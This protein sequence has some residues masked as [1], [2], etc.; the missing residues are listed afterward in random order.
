MIE[1]CFQHMISFLNRIQ[2]ELQTGLKLM[3][4]VKKALH[5]L[6]KFNRPALIFFVL[7]LVPFYSVM[8]QA[9]VGHIWDSNKNP[10]PGA[11]I[12]IADSNMGTISNKD[13]YYILNLKPGR[14]DVIFS[15]IG[16]QNDTLRISVKAGT[17]IKKDIVLKEYLIEGETIMVFAKEYNDAQEIVWKTIQNKNEYLA[18]IKNYE[19]DAYQKTI[20]RLNV[21]KEKQIIG[22]LIETHSKGYFQ[23]PDEFEEVV[24][25][26]KQSANFSDITN[27]FAVG[28]LPNLLDESIKFD[29]LSVVSPLSRKALDYYQY[30]MVDTTYF[31]HR[32]VFNMSFQPKIGGVPLFSGKMSIIDKDFAVIYCELEGKDRITTQLRNHIKITQKFRQF[33]SK[34]WFPTEMTM[35]CNIDLNIPGL[36]ILFWTQHGLISNYR[37]NIKN[38][39]HDFDMNILSYQLLSKAGRDSLWKDMQSIPL[40]LE[41]E[42]A[43]QHIDSVMSNLGFIKKSI[44][45]IIQNFDNI[46]ITGF[47]DFYH[48]NRVEGNYF[49]LGFDS[50]R[51][52]DN[53][54]LRL[55]L[56]HGIEDD[57]FKFRFWLQ[58]NFFND[59]FFVRTQF[60]KRLA[61]L[62]QF[63][64]YNWSDITWQTLITKNDYA[65][66]FYE[67]GAKLA[68]E[69][70]LLKHLK[71]GLEYAWNDQQTAPN[72]IEW[73]PFINNK[74]YRPTVPINDGIIKSV[75]FSLV[76]DN[77]KY[78][79]YGW[80]QTPDLS[81]DFFDI[82]FSYMRSAKKYLNSDFNFNRYH[83]FIN[84]FKQFPPYIHFYTRL[85]GGYLTSDKPLQY[86]FHLDGAYGSFGNPI[87][88]RTI[89]SD[90][91][92]GDRYFAIS[93][94]NN[95]K[96]TIY[97]MFH[98]P[99]IQNTKLDFIVFSNLGWIHNNFKF[100]DPESK[101]NAIEIKKQPLT[102]VGCSIG[103]I[104][105]FFRVDFTW[106]TNYKTGDDFKINLTSRI[107]IR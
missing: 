88:F 41:E 52:F 65:D 61:F 35:K 51:K 15:Y 80:L 42:K 58:N 66:Y 9:L 19:Y 62:D 89:A 92:L 45:T 30:E 10:L 68:L 5:S 20:F 33:D 91:F 102:E 6:V 24:L 85:S 94:E 73:H 67:T 17:Q 26:K 16:Y 14:Y 75:E 93:L 84:T 72:Q 8:A 53:N 69:Y 99:F 38:F 101:F 77:L 87:L 11:N 98:L 31:N 25:A 55:N 57:R 103:N 44:I 29:E 63:Y 1:T 46:L 97:S 36:P 76:S 47:Y 96:N 81:Q 90:A 7:I 49:G 32:M 2:R 40:D 100:P 70:K 74:S 83:L 50:K 37:I 78:F 34:F 86:Y 43:L 56:G 48:F 39:K 3:Q 54:R 104:F 64:R 105:T 18:G 106:R 28:K 95:F 4:Y 21:S 12:Y 82:N 59:R 60:Y 71:L 79:D 13:G 23:Y 107:F 22:G 27:V